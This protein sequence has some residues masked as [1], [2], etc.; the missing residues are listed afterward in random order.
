MWPR[1]IAAVSSGVLPATE[2][3]LV[4]APDVMEA[5]DVVARVEFRRGE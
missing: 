2:S 5:P 1:A 3:F 4:L